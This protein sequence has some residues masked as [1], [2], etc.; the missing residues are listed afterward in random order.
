MQSEKL[1]WPFSLSM[2]LQLQACVRPAP[3]AEEDL[4]SSGVNK[5]LAKTCLLPTSVFDLD[6]RCDRGW[7]AIAGKQREETF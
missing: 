7:T 5:S 1:I 6:D 4:R 2:A 3:S